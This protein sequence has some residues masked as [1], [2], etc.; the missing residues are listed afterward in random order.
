MNVNRFSGIASGM[1][2]ESMVKEMMRV[3]RVRADKYYQS[4]ETNNWRQEQ[5]NDVNKDFANFI[6]DVTKEFG[7]ERKSFGSLIG[8]TSNL[9]W[10]KKAASSNEDIFTAKGTSKAPTGTHK[11]RVE[12]LAEGVSVAS[13]G[14][15]ETTSGTFI[16]GQT[17]ISEL[18]GFGGSGSFEINGKEITVDESTTIN[19]LIQQINTGT[20]D[21]DNNPNTPEISIG[22]Q[23]SFDYMQGRLFLSTKGT[24]KNAQIKVQELDA[25]GNPKDPTWMKDIFKLSDEIFSENGKT[26]QDAIID[27]DGA[28]GLEY[29]SNQF[30]INGIEV[31]L[32]AADPSKEYTIGVDTDVDEVYN[33]IKFFVDKYN[34]LIDKMNKKTSEKRYRTFQ[35]LTK[36][37]RDAMKENDIKLWEQKA[38]SGLLRGDEHINR[39]LQNMRSGLYESVYEQYDPDK[40]IEE[41]KENLLSGFNQLTKIGIKTGEWKDKGKLVI[42]DIKLK[43][44]IREDVDGVLNL[45]FKPS[46]VT[47]ETEGMDDSWSDAQK[48]EYKTKKRQQMRKESGLMNRL[49][50]DVITGMKD[51]VNKAGTG[52][53]ASIYRDVKAN[54]LIDFVTKMGS[55]SHIDKDTLDLEKKMTNEEKRLVQVEQRYWDKFTAMEKALS[56]MQSQS[57]WVAQQLGGM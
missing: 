42:D 21:H 43:E 34:E 56:K 6:L 28:E 22:I 13:S 54:L 18:Q 47:S 45:L 4:R 25:G 17:K 10:V 36:E 38:K 44:A 1:D 5:Y 29:S 33:K 52:E 19:S 50:D 23:A 46:S 48:S 16:T 24:G 39:T 11:I 9:T 8:D 3:Q 55:I 49:F 53:N 7:V 2:T 35:P 27:F 32:K 41:N 57:S 14:K 40:G 26:G 37:Q 15:I 51:I 30:T 20:I 31:N 12:R